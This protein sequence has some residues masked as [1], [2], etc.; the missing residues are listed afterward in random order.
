MDNSG[1]PTTHKSVK[2]LEEVYDTEGNFWLFMDKH[3]MHIEDM[4]D[5]I[6]AHE[7]LKYKERQRES[8]TTRPA[9]AGNSPA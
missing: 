8:S 5:V 2:Q 4:S 6:L 7:I 1:Y 3:A 9:Q